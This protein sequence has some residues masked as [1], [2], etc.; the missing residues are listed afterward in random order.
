MN[1]L[2][3]GAR[4]R[5]RADFPTDGLTTGAK[6]VVKAL[7]RYGLLLAEGG[8]KALTARSDRSTSARWAGLLGD[9]DLV[10]IKPTDFAVVDSGPRIPYGGDC[11]R[12]P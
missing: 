4:L 7:Q 5:L 11:V 12:N 10:S 9:R 8:P 6:V 2:P 1:A 3:L